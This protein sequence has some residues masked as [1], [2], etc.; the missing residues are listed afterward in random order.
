MSLAFE[1]TIE[2]VETAMKTMGDSVTDKSAEDIFDNLDYGQIEKE[3]LR[4]NDM[5]EQIK[6]ALDEIKNQIREMK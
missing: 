3:A 2:D 1:V 5:D 6:Y 4:A